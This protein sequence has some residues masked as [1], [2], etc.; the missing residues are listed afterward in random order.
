MSK[1][2][3]N[4]FV[5]LVALCSLSVILLAGIFI[6]NAFFPATTVV[7][8]QPSI[9]PSLS[10]QNGYGTEDDDKIVD[11]IDL[12]SEHYV[13]FNSTDSGYLLKQNENKTCAIEGQIVSVVAVDGGFCL[14]LIKNG[15]PSIQ[16]VDYNGAPSQILAF[17][18]DAIIQHLAFDGEI[19]ICLKQKGEVDYYFTIY[20]YN[21]NLV[22]TYERVIYTV[23]DVN[24][25][26]LYA[27]SNKIVL[28]FNAEYGS[29]KRGGVAVVYPTSK[30]V[31][32]T[33]FQT[34]SNHSICSTIP[35]LDGFLALCND[36]N[37]TPFLMKIS[38]TWIYEKVY[39]ISSGTGVKLFSNG[40]E[41][42]YSLETDDGV[43]VYSFDQNFTPSLS[44]SATTVLECNFVHSVAVFCITRND[45]TFILHT[46]TGISSIICNSPLSKV[47]MRQ[48]NK[49]CFYYCDTLDP[50]LRIGKTDVFFAS[51]L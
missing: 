21:R 16:V 1:L 30:G 28:F 32:L 36:E 45:K 2:S 11:V 3:K 26:N 18:K 31:D 46:Q 48:R 12:G 19:I 14:H 6:N 4:K 20:K 43:D 41:H 25:V 23:Y 27:L 13:F 22:A 7:Y 44:F 50:A 15:V 35:F 29:V 37:S 24:L 17:D 8:T 40:T 34:D 33:Y 39:S 42:Y 38:D 10:S 9:L 5:L 47:V 49:L 51:L